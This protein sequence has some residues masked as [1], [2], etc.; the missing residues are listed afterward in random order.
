MKFI[1]LLLL[2][3]L[4]A[5]ASMPPMPPVPTVTRQ[6]PLLS[7]KDASTPKAT[8]MLR[9]VASTEPPKLPMI[10][11]YREVQSQY[12]TIEFFAQALQ[13]ANQSVLFEVSPDLAPD[14]WIP[15]AFFPAYPVNQQVFA[16]ITTHQTRLVIRAKATLVMPGGFVK[17]VTTGESV[18]TNPK[19]RGVHA[20]RGAR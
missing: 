4:P 5:Y 14:S 13:P 18:W 10:P 8:P 9:T 20:W 11:F 12:G 6:G 17:T 19:V 1:P 16:G 15:I 3:C 7:P 2:L